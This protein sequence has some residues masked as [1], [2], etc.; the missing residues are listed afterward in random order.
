M[1]P[2]IGVQVVRSI[3]CGK[4]FVSPKDP[5]RVFSLGS[6]FTNMSGL[7]VNVFKEPVT[8]M[9]KKSKK[10][11]LSLEIR[12]GAYVTVEEGQ[13]DPKKVR[14]CFQ[15]VVLESV[16]ICSSPLRFLSQ[17]HF[18]S[19]GKASVVTSVSCSYSQ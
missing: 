18:G 4:E 1:K 6:C 14:A 8:D 11:R 16:K 15:C 13:G 9:G 19:L 2:S 5:A 17:R 3:C 7:Q 10:G 12:D